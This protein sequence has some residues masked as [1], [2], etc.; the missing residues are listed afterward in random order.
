MDEAA[1]FSE[2]ASSSPALAAV[3]RAKALV[4]AVRPRP[5]WIEPS[6]AQ[7]RDI[8]MALRLEGIRLETASSDRVDGGFKFQEA[9]S[10]YEMAFR[11]YGIDIVALSQQQVA[12]RIRESAISSELCV[13]LDTWASNAYGASNKPRGQYLNG[14]AQA[15]DSDPW[16]KS[17]RDIALYSADPASTYEEVRARFL[18]LAKS[19]NGKPLPDH[20]ACLFA[21]YL[22]TA[23]NA[24]PEARRDCGWRTPDPADFW[25]CFD[26]AGIYHEKQPIQLDE[27]I[28][29]FTAAVAIRPSNAVAHN[30]L[31]ACLIDAGRVDEAIYCYR[32]AIRLQPDLAKA[33][34]N[35][36]LALGKMKMFDE[37]IRHYREAIRLWPESGVPCANLGKLL[38]QLG[39]HE[40]AIACLKEALRREPNFRRHID[41]W[42]K[43]CSVRDDSMQQLLVCER[44]CG[45]IRTR[46]GRTAHWALHLLAR[47]SGTTPSARS[48]NQF[49]WNRDIPKS[50]IAWPKP[51]V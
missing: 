44:P 14:I 3:R 36:A 28:R 47:A 50:T 22:G 25:V 5:T 33:H 17:M 4:P 12:P 46:A 19:T 16:R 8:D 23:V 39:A 26:L 11:E 48:E 9:D 31:G 1:Q 27:S 30:N 24:V 37:A 43:S 32:E 41:P 15:A 18:A 2:Q 29:Y 13:V 45:S 49:G 38:N 20:S 10:Q 35:L 40:E 7:R 51:F 21:R 6:P 42:Q 34:N